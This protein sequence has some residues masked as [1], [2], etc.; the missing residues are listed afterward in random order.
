MSTVLGAAILQAVVA[1]AIEILAEGTTDLPVF[2]NA[3]VD[4]GTE[5]NERWLA[6][7]S[8]QAR[9]L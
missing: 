5:H 2:I 3:N 9:H 8:D 7:L 6:R 4:G 1:R